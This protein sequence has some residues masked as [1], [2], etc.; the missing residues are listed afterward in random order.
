MR[1]KARSEEAGGDRNLDLRWQ[2]DA[3]PCDLLAFFL[4]FSEREL[5]KA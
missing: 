3:V 4:P 1:C 2:M 5:W